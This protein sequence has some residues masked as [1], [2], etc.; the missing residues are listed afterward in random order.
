[1]GLPKT[2]SNIGLERMASTISEPQI[3]FI[4]GS[5]RQAEDLH[6]VANEL[7]ECR[8]WFTPY[9][10]GTLVTVLRELGLLERTV[11]GKWLG[12]ECLRYLR[13]H[14]LPI[15]LDGR[16]GRYDLIVTSSDLV[17]PLNARGHPVVIVGTTSRDRTVVAERLVW[18]IAQRMS[19]WLVTDPGDAYRVC[20][21]GDD[22]REFFLELG[23]PRQRMV[24]TGVPDQGGLGP[25]AASYGLAALRI[26]GVCRELL[27]TAA[28]RL[29]DSGLRRLRA[30]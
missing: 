8:V 19:R 17:L 6:R 1:M 2:G 12:E 22:D 23:V 5:S 14:H 24:V 27:G 26:A 7:G 18:R 30:A 11:A 20:V 21:A 28:P 29:A 9:Y 4:C 25:A 3:L 15:D 13:N 10:G 16:R